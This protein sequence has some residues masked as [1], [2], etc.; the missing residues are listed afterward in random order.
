MNRENTNGNVLTPTRTK[1]PDPHASVTPPNAAEHFFLPSLK[2]SDISAFALA[3][4]VRINSEKKSSSHSI[5]SSVAAESFYASCQGDT[6]SQQLNSDE[7]DVFL[8]SQV[9][10]V[11][12]NHVSADE[13]I[14]EEFLTPPQDSRSKS[15]SFKL[16]PVLPMARRTKQSKKKN[17][18]GGEVNEMSVKSQSS[19]SPT[20]KSLGTSTSPTAATPAEVVFE[21]QVLTPLVTP[22]SEKLEN[23]AVKKKR[24]LVS[25]R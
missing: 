24:V 6:D 8:S 19:S 9:E 4:A 15:I 11:N 17:S 12:S 21:T 2:T 13:L 18:K 22:K 25:T 14:S 5:R 16:S 7:E 20:L 23:D 10:E 1:S 3:A